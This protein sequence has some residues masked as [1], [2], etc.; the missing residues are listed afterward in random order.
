MTADSMDYATRQDLFDIVGTVLQAMQA[1]EGRLVSKAEL[2]EMEDRLAARMAT[3][4]E[5]AE[6]EARLATK[7]ELA[8]MEARLVASMATKLELSQ[9]EG[10]LLRE[11]GAHTRASNEEMTAKVGILDDK[12]ADLPARV[13]ALESVGPSPQKRTPGKSG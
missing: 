3:K 1:M 6:M 13:R 12:Y 10:R 2:A 11:L 7:V 4:A 8:G 9:M 5:L